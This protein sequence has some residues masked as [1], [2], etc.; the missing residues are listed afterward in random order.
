MTLAR[1]ELENQLLDALVLRFL[2]PEM[3]DLAI[4]ELN[5][6]LREKN[7]QMEVERQRASA[8]KRPIEK[9]MGIVQLG[10]QNIVKAIARF[11][12]DFDSTF[13]SQPH[14]LRSRESAL[15]GKLE[16]A[17]VSLTVAAPMELGP[18]LLE[19]MDDLQNLLL[20]DRPAAQQAIQRFIGNPT[21]T[22]IQ[23]PDGPAY[24]V[25]G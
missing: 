11:G 20:K 12:P 19:K 24:S 17:F 6:Q 18:Y 9:E 21:L 14:G 1:V 10:V 4:A 22:P 25:N 16:A 5:Q 15:K 2:Q 3:I 13:E 8:S 7:R 23:G